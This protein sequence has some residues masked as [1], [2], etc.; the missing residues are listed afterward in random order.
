MRLLTNPHPTHITWG[1]SLGALASDTYARLS[2]GI[3]MAGLDLPVIPSSE[4]TRATARRLQEIGPL[5]WGDLTSVVQDHRTWISEAAFRRL[6]LPI[7]Y[8][9]T[10][11][12]QGPYI[13]C[14]GGQFWSLRSRPGFPGGIYE[15]LNFPSPADVT[16]S[17][18]YYRRWIGVTT[19]R[20]SRRDRPFPTPGHRF[21]PLYPLTGGGVSWSHYFTVQHF[22][23]CA[24]ARL[25]TSVGP[26][27]SRIL[28]HAICEPPVYRCSAQPSPALIESLRPYL[29]HATAWDVYVDGSWYPLPGS[30][31]SL[32]G[33]AGNHTGGCSLIFVASAVPLSSGVVI[34]RM[35][36]GTRSTVHGGGA[37]LME[38]LSATAGTILLHRLGKQGRVITDNQGIEK[39][40]LDRKRMTRSGSRQGSSIALPAW[41]ILQEGQITLHWHRGHP[42]R[43]E[44]DRTTWSRDDWGSYLANL[45]A[46]P[47]ADPSPANSPTRIKQVILTDLATFRQQLIPHTRWQL[48]DHQDEAVLSTLN[49]RFALARSRTYRSTRDQYRARRGAPPKWRT[50][51]PTWVSH[52]WSLN[53]ASFRRRGTLLKTMWDQW[54]HG[55]NKAVAGLLD[56]HC[57]LCQ[58]PIYSQAHILCVCPALEH[59]REDHLRSLAASTTRLPQG[60][61][62][63]LLTT[64]LDMV[65][66]WSPH[67]DRVFL[68]TGMLS[69]PQRA[70]L[71]PFIR[72]LPLACSRSLLTGT[73]RSLT[74]LTRTLWLTFRS[75]AA[76]A[77]ADDPLADAS[78]HFPTTDT[79]DSWDLPDEAPPDPP[80]RVEAPPFPMRRG[81]DPLVRLREEGD[82]G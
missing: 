2:S 45:Y 39:Q 14:C 82:F 44:K 18:I 19:F 53:K 36:A 63:Q 40:L 65:N 10:P 29:A 56:T 76:E 13:N 33:E 15:L 68:W 20:T 61:Q 54:W 1:S 31:E 72:C 42:E 73:C 32:L 7:P 21:K 75:L 64:Y 81:G 23:D 4:Q 46:P 71:D 57:P 27:D 55:D 22:T 77:A 52:V 38:L 5:L 49:A 6:R 43:R 12:P 16:H 3:P 59:I 60:P 70:V 24:H 80:Y 66:T 25:L 37:R 79:M 62:R 48:C 74:R 67:E 26:R 34:M 51:S 30:A 47:R 28:L 17:I 50:T 8:P 78:P 41:H 9:T 35:D 69:Q 58:D 11:C